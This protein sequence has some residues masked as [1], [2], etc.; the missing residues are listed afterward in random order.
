MISYQKM[1]QKTR[2]FVTHISMAIFLTIPLLHCTAIPERSEVSIDEYTKMRINGVDQQV[3]IR[4]NNLSAPLLLF[5]HGGPGHPHMHQAG[6]ETDLLMNRFIVVQW[7]QRGA[8]A[9]YAEGIDSQSLTI[10]Q[11][12]NDTITLIETLLKRFN[13]KKIY[14]IG[15][16]WGSYLGLRVVNRNPHIVEAF[17][18]VGLVTDMIPAY[19]MMRQKLIAH[20]GKIIKLEKNLQKKKNLIEWKKQLEDFDI[21]KTIANKDW[22]GFLKNYFEPRTN[23]GFPYS[24]KDIDGHNSHIASEKAIKEYRLQVDK[25]IK[26]A[27]G[28]FFEVLK[29]EPTK[30]IKKIEV[31][32]L[33]I[34]GRHDYNTEPISAEKYMKNLRAPC[35]KTIWFE[36]SAHMMTFEEPEKFKQV[37]LEQVLN[38]KFCKI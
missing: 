16:S 11:M 35:K 17:V 27:T 9:S 36:N 12:E 19:K 38:L 24:L 37:M 13:R 20:A 6:S 23:L 25:G 4:G 18:A 34:L 5:L 1:K 14:L 21:E 22:D 32:I 8:G 29:Q 30:V 33:T 15:H 31:P 7:D 28:L 10:Q 26:L 3:W 2:M